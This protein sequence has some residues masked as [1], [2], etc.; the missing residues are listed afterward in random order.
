MLYSGFI[1]EPRRNTAAES[2]TVRQPG[3]HAV[4][5]TVGF[6]ILGVAIGAL[7]GCKRLPYRTQLSA[8]DST[9]RVTAITTDAS[10]RAIVSATNG[11]GTVVCAEPSPDAIASLAQSASGALKANEK[12]AVQFAASI[13]TQVASI[14]LRTQSI[15]LW[16]DEAYRTCEGY[17]AGALSPTDFAFFHRRFQNLIIASMAIEQ[18]TGVARPTTVVVGAPNAAEATQGLTDANA[19]LA[20]AEADLATLTKQL[21]DAKEKDAAASTDDTKAEVAKTQALVETKQKLVDAT[22]G[23]RDAAQKALQTATVQANVVPA[24]SSSVPQSIVDATVKIA[25]KA[26]DT[27]Y[28]ADICYQVLSNAGAK[29]FHEELV[30]NCI[31]KFKSD[32]QRLNFDIQQKRIALAAQQLAVEQKTL[33]ATRTQLEIEAKQKQLEA[34]KQ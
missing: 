29:Q 8:A 24:P 11:T 12:V 34:M 14:G 17:L 13:A 16:R 2:T 28:S 18:L 23:W 6:A 1:K 5:L 15:T 32:T 21:D 31:A 3:G 30:S 20:K 7:A 33:E 9:T 22:R 26:M 19:S 25:E 10:M 27:P 4:R